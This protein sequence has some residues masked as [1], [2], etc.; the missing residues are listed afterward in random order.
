MIR[1]AFATLKAYLATRYVVEAQP[2]PFEL[3]IGE[4]SDALAALQ[5]EHGVQSSCFVT[6]FNPF[7]EEVSPESN[8]AAQLRL[9]RHLH[10]RG[11]AFLYGEGRGA[12]SLWPAEP[13]FL[14]LGVSEGHARELCALFDQNAVV[15]AAAEA[16]PVLLLH[17]NACVDG[18]VSSLDI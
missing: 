16:R 9:R 3:R 10:D 13:S 15:F 18:A 2:R 12:D 6:A 1:I 4:S 5:G 11:I 17:P 14:A 7:G 8:E